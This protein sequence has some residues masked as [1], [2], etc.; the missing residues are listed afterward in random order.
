MISSHCRDR[1]NDLRN[2]RSRVGR[3]P[4]KKRQGTAG[5]LVAKV[6]RS[7]TA[8]IPLLDV[9]VRLLLLGAG[10]GRDDAIVALENQVMQFSG[11]DRPQRGEL[12]PGVGVAENVQGP[13]SYGPA[14]KVGVVEALPVEGL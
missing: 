12:G 2:R 1:A 7:G 8:P 6:R 4:T 9:P 13:V 3:P 14:A 5:N 10:R 11:G